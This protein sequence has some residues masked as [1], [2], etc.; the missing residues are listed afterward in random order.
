MLNV[1]VKEN[2][3]LFVPGEPEYYLADDVFDKL[4]KEP[5]MTQKLYDFFG[6][7]KCIGRLGALQNNGKYIEKELKCEIPE[8]E[9]GCLSYYE[10]IC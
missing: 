5:E 6:E 8:I 2:Q 10:K 7:P 4:L 3:L 1:V 9:S